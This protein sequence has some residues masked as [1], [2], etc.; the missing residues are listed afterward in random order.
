MILG[1]K[2]HDSWHLRQYSNS[3]LKKGN[4]TKQIKNINSCFNKILEEE[5]VKFSSQQD[6]VK[7]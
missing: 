5:L 6:Y 3:L 1:N 7:Q 2:A 4:I